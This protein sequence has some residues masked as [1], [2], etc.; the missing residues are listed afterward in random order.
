[1]MSLARF[2]LHSRKKSRNAH[3]HLGKFAQVILIAKLI[4]DFRVNIETYGKSSYG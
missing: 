3:F 1:M 2:C 4:K